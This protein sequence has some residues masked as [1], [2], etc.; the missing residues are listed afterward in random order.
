M[1]LA[2]LPRAYCW[3]RRQAT[4]LFGQAGT[5]GA[6]LLVIPVLLAFLGLM[7]VDLCLLLIP[8]QPISHF[9]LKLHHPSVTWSGGRSF[10]ALAM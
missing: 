10:P 5:H 2:V 6:S 7:Q 1:A 8:C 4:G 9:K 3:K